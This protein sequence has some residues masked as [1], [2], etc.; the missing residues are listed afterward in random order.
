MNYREEKL[1]LDLIKQEITELSAKKVQ[2][3]KKQ[4]FYERW[5]AKEPKIEAI[6]T[7]IARLEKDKEN[8]FEVIQVLTIN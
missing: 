1:E 3:E 6:E 7:E 8:Y 5:L 2:L 4:W